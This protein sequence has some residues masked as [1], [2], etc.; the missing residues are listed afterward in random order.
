VSR[1]ARD[2]VWDHSKAYGSALTVMLCLAEHSN[3]EKQHKSWP[4]ID[5][6]AK[7]TR[8]SP[9]QV[10][11]HLKAL[12]KLGELRVDL[13]AGRSRQNEYWILLPG[14]PTPPGHPQ[15]EV[16]SV[17]QRGG[18][19]LGKGLARASECSARA[20]KG[21]EGDIQGKERVSSKVKEGDAGDTQSLSEPK[22]E[23][24]KNPLNP[25]EG[26]RLD[27]DVDFWIEGIAAL[28]HV[29]AAA[30]DD[31]LVK[32]LR[33][34]GVPPRDQFK[35]F[36]GYMEADAPKKWEQS[37]EALLLRCRKQK[38]STLIRNLYEAVAN[39]EDY[40]DLVNP[41]PY[42]GHA[43]HVPHEPEYD[44]RT[45]LPEL[46]LDPDPPGVHTGKPVTERDRL[47]WAER[48]E[49]LRQEWLTVSW[50]SL[51]PSVMADIREEHDRRIQ[52]VAEANR[53]RPQ[54]GLAPPPPGWFGIA[55]SMFVEGEK[56]CAAKNRAR[57][58]GMYWGDVSFR[59]RQRIWEEYKRREAEKMKGAV[60]SGSDQ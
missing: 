57:L 54:P 26:E 8:Q 31:R 13:Q 55:M 5:R 14:L 12:Q 29:D 41:G 20:S 40:D 51:L 15:N 17:A 34:K 56:E 25:P 35:V 58:E 27:S 37:E 44:W 48:N 53:Y 50:G 6:I 22:K 21:L 47:E 59:D 36:R 33:K 10:K 23:N 7:R 30:V 52:A 18:K 45:M 19:G 2:A 39:A 43:P 1:H 42:I 4:G 32:I 3:D 28:F 60:S 11:R 38:I 16:T 46:Y 9:R 24:Q 49:R